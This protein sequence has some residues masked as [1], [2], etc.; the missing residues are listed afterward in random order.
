MISPRRLR[1]PV[2]AKP[3]PP[4]F[5][6]FFL[7]RRFS[8][9]PLSRASSSHTSRREPSLSLSPLLPSPLLLSRQGGLNGR[10]E[11][12]RIEREVSP[13]SAPI[14]F[15]SS[16]ARGEGRRNIDEERLSSFSRR[17]REGYSVIGR[18]NKLLLVQ[19]FSFPR[20]CVA[21]QFGLSN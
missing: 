1:S 19:L 9:F 15:L 13:K 17:K 18:A 20:V 11:I 3:P 8:S 5:L 4:P 14:R 6:P 12:S 10:L 7:T 2:S 21:F 16:F